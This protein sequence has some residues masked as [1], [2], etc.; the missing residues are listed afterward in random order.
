MVFKPAGCHVCLG[1]SDN[2]A[3]YFFKNLEYAYVLWDFLLCKNV[4]DRS[5][6]EFH[7]GHMVIHSTTP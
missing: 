4:D 2:Q 1:K 7:I 3:S 6:L 5:F